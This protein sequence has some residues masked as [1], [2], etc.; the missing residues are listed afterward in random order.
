MSA[1][2]VAIT[3]TDADDLSL[4]LHEASVAGWGHTQTLRRRIKPKPGPLRPDRMAK[5]QRLPSAN[6]WSRATWQRTFWH[7]REW[8]MTA[9]VEGVE[10]QSHLEILRGLGCDTAQGCLPAGKANPRTARSCPYGVH[11]QCL[12]L[13]GCKKSWKALNSPP[14]IPHQTGPASGQAKRRSPPNTDTP[15]LPEPLTPSPPTHPS[16]GSGCLARHRGV[17]SCPPTR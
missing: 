1:T 6:A 2:S 17:F 5:P 14:R 9:P 16:S 13:E 10:R 15:P 4:T 3:P 8:T 7:V 11:D 12:R